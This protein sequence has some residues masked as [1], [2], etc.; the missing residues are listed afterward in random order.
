M[1]SSRS[2]ATKRCSI[3][4]VLL[5]VGACSWRRGVAR[6][7]LGHA[8]GLAVERGREEQRLAVGRALGHDAVDRG[9]EAHVEHAVGL[10]EDEDAHAVEG[11]VAALEE[12]LQAA[13]GGHDDVGLRGRA[14]LLDDA[15]A[16]VDRGD[17]QRAG[18]RQRADV[19]DDLAGQL[20][21]GGEDEGRRTAVVGLDAVRDG[22]AEGD[23]LARSGRRLREHVVPG[24]DVG[25]DELLDGEGLGDAALGECARDCAGHAEIGEGLL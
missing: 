19:V 20:A 23:G 6:V 24:E 11:Q 13:G 5:T 18:V 15:H 10:V 4:A 8:A 7:A 1:R 17:L 12:V 16:A 14:G 22:G 3:A 21:R 25:D 9:L 2:T